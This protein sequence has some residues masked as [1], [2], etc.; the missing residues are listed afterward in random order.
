MRPFL[1]M[2]AAL[3]AFAAALVWCYVA[4]T[5]QPTGPLTQGGAYVLCVA[6]AAWHLICGACFAFAALKS[7]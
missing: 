1:L 3:V 4:P 6:L 2:G 5:A 7:D